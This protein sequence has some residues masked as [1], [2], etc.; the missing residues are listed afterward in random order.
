MID[1]VLHEGDQR[2]YDALV[3]DLPQAILLTGPNGFGLN[4]IAFAISEAMD[5]I[6]VVLDPE[7]DE[8]VDVEKGSISIEMIRRL[9]EWTKTTELKHRVI[10]INYAEKM[11]IPAQNAFLKLLEEPSVNTHFILVANDPSKLLPTIHSRAQT[12]ELRSITAEQSEKILDDNNVTSVQK[13]AQ[14]LFMASGLPGELTHLITD[15]EYFEIRAGIVRSA[16][17]YLQ[18]SAYDRMKIAQAYKDNR[19]NALLLLADVLKLLKQNIESGKTELI[20]KINEVLKVYD[21]IEANGNIRLQLA[22][23]MV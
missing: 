1:V 11:G 14:L 21:R 13:R 20:P 22:S 16:R 19:N 7:K 10:I 15:D 3:N 17:Q 9:Y 6:P 23:V 4:T 2:Q 5:T 8:V 18:G 12:F